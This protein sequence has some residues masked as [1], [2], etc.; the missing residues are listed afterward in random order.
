M[1]SSLSDFTRRSI[2]KLLVF[3]TNVYVGRIEVR[4]RRY[5][6]RG[7]AIFAGNH[8]SGLLD[9]MVIMSAFRE[10]SFTSV[11]KDSLFHQPIVSFFVKAMRAVPV[12]KG[13][14]PDKPMHEQPSPKERRAMND[15]MF[16][17]VQDR[18][19]GGINVAIFPEV[20]EEGVE[21]L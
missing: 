12:A 20:C 15:A 3:A 2:K 13:Y 19:R 17:T 9:P 4:G 6:P 18:L 16:R 8:P 11:A 7:A 10:R 5:L 21:W 1:S 14:D